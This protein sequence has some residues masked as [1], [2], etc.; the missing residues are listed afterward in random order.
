MSKWGLGL[1]TEV[2]NSRLPCPQFP[3]ISKS[4]VGREVSMES[5]D[6]TFQ[7]GLKKLMTTTI[8][9]HEKKK[10]SKK[11]YDVC[12]CVRAHVWVAK[13]TNG[14]QSY[15]GWGWEGQ[16]KGG[17]QK[18]NVVFACYVSGTA[19]GNLHTVI[20]MVSIATLWSRY[21]YSIL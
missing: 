3:H 10:E 5:K 19:L 7:Q 2:F 8:Q 20:H 17:K 1:I 18:F 13:H 15:G 14:T 12:V 21:Y 16:K 6:R 4:R 11:N 9:E